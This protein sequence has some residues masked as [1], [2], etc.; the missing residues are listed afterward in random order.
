VADEQGVLAGAGAVHPVQRAGYAQAGLVETGHLRSGDPVCDLRKELVE[1]VGGA[2]GH[3]RH[4]ALR[5]RGTEQLGQRG[6]GALFRQEL[7][8]REQPSQGSK[9]CPI[10][11]A[12]AR[13]GD[14]TAQHR[15]LVTQD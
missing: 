2:L 13:C 1:P 7:P 14:L 10:G 8:E 15:H 3:R 12:G 4:G 6:G 5:D 11:P 9:Q